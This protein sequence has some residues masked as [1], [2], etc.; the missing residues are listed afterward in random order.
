M[1]RIIYLLVILITLKSYSQEININELNGDWVKFKIEMKDSSSL[2]DRFYKDSS[3]VNFLIK[4]N[5]L[6]TN[7]NPLFKKENSCIN[8]SLNDNYIKT[9]EF[10]GYFIEKIKNDTLIITENIDN[11][12]DDKI[13]RFY[14]IREQNKFEEFK[15]QQNGSTDQVAKPYYTPTLKS[16]LTL[17]LNNAFKEKHSNF[18]AKGTIIIDIKNKKIE[19]SIYT[20]DTNDSTK[21]KRVISVLNESF[22]LWNLERFKDLETIKLPFVF[23]DEKTKTFRGITIVFFTNSYK[24]LDE[25]YG[26][27]I[28]DIRDAK[29]FFNKGLKAYQKNDFEKAIN[30]FT[31]SYNLDSVNIDALYNI[32]A[33][34][35]ETGSLELA[36]VNWK[37]LSELGQKRGISLL[38]NH[39]L[40]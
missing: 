2:I 14:F 32:A 13:K 37:K 27:D 24:K 5:Q 39:C 3:Y 15:N 8:F 22:S 10:A 26:D 40:N 21:I 17:Q 23:R 7:N 35:Y 28:Y 16:S 6:C 19:S 38:E 33:I 36:C 9:S 29:K 4:K 12:E 25:I 20:S 31:K 11:L 30:F 1:R 18:K 34:Y